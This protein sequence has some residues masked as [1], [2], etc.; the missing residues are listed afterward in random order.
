MDLGPSLI[1]R[2]SFAPVAAAI[3]KMGNKKPAS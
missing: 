2:K 3:E 1:H